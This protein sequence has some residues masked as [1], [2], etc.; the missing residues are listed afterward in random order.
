MK[1]GNVKVFFKYEKQEV[2]DTIK[3]GTK[4]VRK[5]D[6]VIEAIAVNTENRQELARRRV[7]PRHGD[8]PNKELGRKYAFKKLMDHAMSNNILPKPTVGELWKQFGSQCKQPNVK[9]AY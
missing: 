5:E 8:I 7:L 2:Q 6:G 1:V 9:L 4:L 3:G